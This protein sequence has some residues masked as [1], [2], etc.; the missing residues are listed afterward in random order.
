MVYNQ[1][2]DEF[3][4]ALKRFTNRRSTPK[5]LMTDNAKNFIKGKSTIQ[6]MFDRLNNSKTHQRL[7]E[8]MKIKW[9]HSTSRSPS[10]NGQVEAAVKIIK[11]PLYN[12][13]NGRILSPNEFYTLLTDV[14]SIVNSRP[15]GA[16]SE[17]ADDGNIITITPN[18]L[19]HGKCLR[20]LPIEI[21]K[22][23]ENVKKEK[24][25]REKWILRKRIVDNFWSAWKKEYLTNL[26]EYHS[27][28][29]K[30]QNLKENDC[31]LVLTEKI[32]KHDWPIGA[33]NQILLGRDGL[34]RSVE[35]RLPLKAC[36]IDDEGKR[37][38]QYKVIKRGIES[39]IP[40]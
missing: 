37:R 6:S 21:Y 38:K 9:Y 15:L 35:V 27:K 18:H 30:M 5:I 23:I 24:S 4:L 29:Q 3:L 17:S 31:V 32:T 36:D 40:L 11:K 16:M 39:V 22:G 28:T 34:V 19:L 13:L 20:P 12:S 33:I 10:H 1:T 26:R 25:T 7:G 14:E 8:E 2:A